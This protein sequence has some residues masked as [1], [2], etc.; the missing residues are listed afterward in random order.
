M[1][2][3]FGLGVSLPASR[4]AGLGFNSCQW[5]SLK[6]SDWPQGPFGSRPKIMEV[7]RLEVLLQHLK[8]DINKLI[9][10]YMYITSNICA[11]V[12]C[13][14]RIQ[15][16]VCILFKLLETPEWGSRQEYYPHVTSYAWFWSRELLPTVLRILSKAVTLLPRPELTEEILG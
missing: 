12:V 8:R 14:F 1:S 6:S 3:Q 9:L 10:S 5:L 7:C 4:L 16:G 2:E 15:K 11:E 13:S